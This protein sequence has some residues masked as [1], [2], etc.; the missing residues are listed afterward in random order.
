MSPPDDQAEK[1][2]TNKNHPDAPGT[3]P[4]PTAHAA[5]D[6]IAAAEDRGIKVPHMFVILIGIVAFFTALTW[7]VPAGQYDR[8]PDPANPNRMLIDP[9]SFQYV[10]QSGVGL[11]QML[12]SLQE[13]VVSAANISFMIFMCFAALYMVEKTG[14]LDAV[15]NALLKHTERGGNT[16]LGIL[17]VMMVGMSAW[18]STGTFSY[19]QIVIF[20]PI[21]CTL[22]I[23]L[24][25]DALV[26]MGMS[27]VVV[28]VGFGT[29]TVNPFTVGV[30]QGVSQVP[31]FSGLEYR[32]I[33]WAVLTVITI[34]YILW[35]AHRVKKDPSKSLVKDPDFSEFTM[36]DARLSTRFTTQRALVLVALGLAIGTMVWG[37]SSQGWFINEI[38]A[39]FLGLSI[40]VAAIMRW[41]PNRWA[42]VFLK[43]LQAAML[44]G[45][46]VGLSRG[47][48]VV[49]E[50]GQIVDTLIRGGASMLDNLPLFGSAAVMLFFQM[51]LNLI[52]PSGSGQ[53]A[54]SMPIIAPISDVIGLDRQIAVLIF[55]FGDGLSNLI[56]PTSFVFIGCAMAKVPITKYYRWFFPLAGLLFVA[57]C[58]LIFIAIE[59]GYQ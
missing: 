35:Y 55:Q 16:A 14:A 47:I 20:I 42:D 33:C 8:Y 28:G 19:E 32:I 39:T 46:V 40:A 50:K 36:T 18:A 37:L 24:G 58:I 29:G 45:M 25:F 57:Q 6:P 26:G 12:L 49:L 43:G 23:A 7:I 30:A 22:A 4:D 2:T 10:P 1:A 44:T 3:S 48:L 52:V 5:D 9:D 38:G 54:V 11:P 53:A 21:F 15:I 56:W 41:S 51:F 13:G 34:A 17:V 31:L 27:F 59:I